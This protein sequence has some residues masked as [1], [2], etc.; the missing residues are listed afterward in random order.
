MEKSIFTMK[1]HKQILFPINKE[2]SISIIEWDGKKEVA[3]VMTNGTSSPLDIEQ[4][5]SA[6]SLYKYLRKY[7]GT[8]E[9]L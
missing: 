3:V 8:G 1:N 5:Y 2:E 6:Y 7:F 4:L 9:V